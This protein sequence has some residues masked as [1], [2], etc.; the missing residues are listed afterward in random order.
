MEKT[1]YGP[2]TKAISEKENARWTCMVQR[3][4]F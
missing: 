1:V 2:L 3:A 4:F